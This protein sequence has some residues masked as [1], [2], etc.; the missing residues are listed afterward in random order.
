MAPRA[1]GACVVPV[2][3]APTPPTHV[4]PSAPS[5]GDT[6][7]HPRPELPGVAERRVVCRIS[8]IDR[9]VVV[10]QFG[11]GRPWDSR[12]DCWFVICRPSS[13]Q[14][15]QVSRSRRAWRGM[16]RLLRQGDIGACKWPVSSIA[17]PGVV[18]GAVPVPARDLLAPISPRTC[19]QLSRVI[20]VS[21]ELF[22]SW[23]ENNCCAFKM[24]FFSL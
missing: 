3:I 5:R 22:Y 15:A 12:A 16:T 24:F 9:P 1:R 14:W 4:S 21:V 13:L 17:A 6:Q 19:F 2:M 10:S 18:R 23:F 8:R 7:F 20:F 11:C